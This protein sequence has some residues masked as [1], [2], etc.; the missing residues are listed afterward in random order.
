MH[1]NADPSRI[2][3]LQG[4]ADIGVNSLTGNNGTTI[5]SCATGPGGRQ[6][7]QRFSALV[8]ATN[9]FWDRKPP[10]ASPCMR[11]SKIRPDLPP[12]MV[13]LSELNDCNVASALNRISI[14][15]A[16]SPDHKLHPRAGYDAHRYLPSAYCLGEIGNFRFRIANQ[17]SWAFGVI[18]SQYVNSRTSAQAHF[19]SYSIYR[20]C[21]QDEFPKKGWNALNT[22]HA[23]S[24][25]AITVSN[26]C[27]ALLSLVT[28]Y[29]DVTR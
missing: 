16:L 22:V 13:A 29:N 27:N 25:H 12:C 20:T 8:M 10:F 21:T 17:K 4:H 14:E 23:F 9:L 7:F 24:M 2:L 19:Q 11:E 26:A 18:F 1:T 6:L 3:P 28:L 5:G 15:S